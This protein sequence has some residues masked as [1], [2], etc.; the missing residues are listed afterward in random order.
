M[1]DNGASEKSNLGLENRALPKISRSLLM[2]SDGKA[3]QTQPYHKGNVK[4]DLLKA[5]REILVSGSIEDISARRLCRDVGVTSA[6]FYNHYPSLEFLLLELA[7]E[8]FK[9]RATA[10]KR[11]LKLNLPREEAMLQAAHH[12]VDF[13]LKETQ[14]FR[15]MYG[16]VKDISENPRYLIES[17]S[18]FRVLVHIIYGEDLYNKD[19]IPYS[20]SHCEIAYAFFAFIYGLAQAVSQGLFSNPSGTK[21][22][23]KNFVEALTLS[24]IRG[25]EHSS[26]NQSSSA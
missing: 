25:I 6:N 18:S 22:E 8:S 17:D 16:H 3:N 10:L 15:L 5:A 13:S 23:R 4:A 12:T 24:F 11:I 21:A 19:D 2:T 9:Q 1:G 20:H 26:V 14:L 7:A